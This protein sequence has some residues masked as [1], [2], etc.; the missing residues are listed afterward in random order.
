MSEDRRWRETAIRPCDA[1][2]MRLRGEA[3]VD[4]RVWHVQLIGTGTKGRI[5]K[6]MPAAVQAHTL[7]AVCCFANPKVGL[8][9]EPGLSVALAA[10]VCSM[11]HGMLWLRHIMDLPAVLP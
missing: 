3:G 7:A 4:V 10:A 1:C 5:F 11:S 6:G 9:I 8:A 2:G